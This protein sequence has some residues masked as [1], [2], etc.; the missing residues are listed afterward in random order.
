MQALYAVY[1]KD[2]ARRHLARASVA[3]KLSCRQLTAQS[4]DLGAVL[5]RDP[6][7]ADARWQNRLGYL[8]GT[9]PD[10]DALRQDRE[11]N[12]HNLGSEIPSSCT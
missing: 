9:G 1:P 12:T 5:I 8:E 2:I 11:C 7:P 4:A 3:V 6:Y 10:S